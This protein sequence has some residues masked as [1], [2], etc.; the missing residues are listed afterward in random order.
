MAKIIHEARIA[1]VAEFEARLADPAAAY[2]Q[3]NREWVDGESTRS[4]G[5]A[6]SLSATD[7]GKLDDSRAPTGRG[8]PGRHETRTALRPGNRFTALQDDAWADVSVTA[9]AQKYIAAE[10]R[11]G[12]G[13]S[14]K[15]KHA[16]RAW[17]DKTRRQFESAAM[18]LGKAF[19]GP[20]CKMQQDDLDRF[21]A[22]LDRLPARSHH[23]CER[24]K[25][26]T[27]EEICD[28]ADE[29]LKAGKLSPDEIGL[30][31]PTT[32]RHFRFLRSLCEWVRKRAPQMAELNW[33]SYIFADDR[34]SRDQR[35]A[36]TPA[37]GQEMF[38]LPI[39][40]GCDG[41]DRRNHPGPYIFHDAGYWLP[42]MCWYSGARREEI[43]KLMTADVLLEDDVPYLNIAV[44]ASGR[45]K[46]ARSVRIIPIHGELLR[47]GLLDY[48]EAI[49]NEGY[50]ILFPDL[51]PGTS[52][53]RMGD[54]YYKRYWRSV[55][56]HLPFLQPGQALHSHR[57]MVS[58]QLKDA[59]VFPEKRNDLLGHGSKN[60]MADRYSKA[61]RLRKLIKIVQRIPVTT[62]HLPTTPV[63][64]CM[65]YWSSPQSQSAAGRSKATHAPTEE[66]KDSKD[67][68]GTRCSTLYIDREC[69]LPSLWEAGHR[70]VDYVASRTY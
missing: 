30:M 31:P 20:I 9:A 64:L 22:L 28:E 56:K 38:T 32:N 35:P 12:G 57:H 59:E 10:P 66:V 36:F 44:T 27:L 67:R 68:T 23:K 13:A 61:T 24:H 55:A 49:R 65:R 47:L 62:A 34:D 63:N 50:Q 26:M 46:N 33:D 40:T 2:A 19:P 69:D 6:P 15:L 4:Y 48:V 8:W 11:A 18:L 60:P 53:Q 58:T 51:L 7:R 1:A 37:Q 45:L 16:R 41:A 5:T 17:D 43:A 52:R 39:W 54:V 42:L 3:Y 25:D 21:V 29:M 14:Q 70:I